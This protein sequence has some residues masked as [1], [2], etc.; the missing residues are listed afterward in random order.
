MKLR[1]AAERLEI[2]ESILVSLL[3]QFVKTTLSDV[4]ELAR[5][6][7]DSDSEKAVQT[8]HSIRG[9]AINLELA[10]IASAAAQVEEYALRN[11]MNGVEKAA[12]TVKKQLYL[13]SA[14]LPV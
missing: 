1:E 8:A 6:V 3:H 9:A 2:D 10:Q 11:D 13:L 7:E 4:E 12:Y 5:A 14:N